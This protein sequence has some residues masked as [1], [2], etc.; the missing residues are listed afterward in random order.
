MLD[1]LTGFIFLQLEHP[2]EGDRTVIGWEIS[3]LPSP[4][5]L[6]SVHLQLHRGTTGCVFLHLSE[7]AGLA[8]IVRQVQLR[9]QVVRYK[10]SYRLLAED[11]LH[12]AI[13][14]RL[15]IVVSIVVRIDAI[16]L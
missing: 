12:G 6:D 4:I 11:V 3:Q 5:P 8:I 1:G 16:M 2:F 13:P 7:G 9:L 14:Q 15:A 10:S